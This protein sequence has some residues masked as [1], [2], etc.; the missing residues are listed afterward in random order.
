[1]EIL[2]NLDIDKFINWL[3][4]DEKTKFIGYLMDNVYDYDEDDTLDE[5][6]NIEV[7]NFIRK[8]RTYADFDKL[9]SANQYEDVKDRDSYIVNKIEEFKKLRQ[10]KLE[11][12]L[13]Y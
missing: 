6:K 1:M 7:L 11:R 10:R 3:K 12:L 13:N 8:Y 2:K 9:T 5:Q 4:E